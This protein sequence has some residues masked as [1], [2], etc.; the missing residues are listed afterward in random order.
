MNTLL[1][2][3][4]RA[5]RAFL[6]TDAWTEEKLCA[7]LAHAQDKLSYWS[8]CCLVGS[9]NAPHALKGVICGGLDSVE[10]HTFEA[11]ALPGADTAEE[12]FYNL[13]VVFDLCPS[14][15]D[16]DTYRR[17]ILVP[18]I[19]AELRRRSRLDSVASTN[20]KSPEAALAESSTVATTSA[21][22]Q[23]VLSA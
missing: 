10:D 4:K 22:R 7:L 12:G 18:I 9:V 16:G 5:I 19:R 20:L 21:Q 23:E 8:C 3:S 14:S 1:K 2:T 17:L 11:R 13:P 6:Q 15:D